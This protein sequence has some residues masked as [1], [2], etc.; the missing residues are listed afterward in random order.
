[1]PD[2]DFEAVF[3][4]YAID[5]SLN[6]PDVF[7]SLQELKYIFLGIREQANKI[8]QHPSFGM[9]L[10][11]TH[12]AL[13]NSHLSVTNITPVGEKPTFQIFEK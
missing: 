3:G 5:F 8:R 6:E 4:T 1:M 10:F 11:E 2:T 13:R 12:F 7:I 9:F